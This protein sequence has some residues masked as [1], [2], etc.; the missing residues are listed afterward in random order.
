M[1]FRYYLYISDTKV[2]MLLAQIDPGFA[3]SRATEVSLDLKVVGAKRSMANS[4]SDRIARLERVVRHIEDHGDLGTVDEPGQFFW[5]LLPMRWGAIEGR[6]SAVYFG[7]RAERTIVGL[8]GSLRHVVGTA[9][10]AVPEQTIGG[11]M[12]PAMLD[13]LDSDE[14]GEVDDGSLAVVLRANAGL[15]GPAQNVEFV[16]KRLMQ[17]TSPYPEPNQKEMTVLLG[18]PLYV[19]MAD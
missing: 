10:D 6:P 17:G 14:D 18:S 11:S 4:G 3:R 7:G 1:S 16:A 13:W 12:L 8:G 15:R 9:A 5:G 2:D 19:A